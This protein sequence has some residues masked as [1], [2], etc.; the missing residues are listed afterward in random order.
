M[1]SKLVCQRHRRLLKTV[2]DT[3]CLLEKSLERYCRVFA[4]I[5]EITAHVENAYSLFLLLT[6]EV[7]GTIKIIRFETVAGR[8]FIQYV[9]I[10]EWVAHKISDLPYVGIN[11]VTG[12]I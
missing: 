3:G 8:R 1:H 11:N 5:P 10:V 4:K 12:Y 2:R 7:M 6:D 9:A